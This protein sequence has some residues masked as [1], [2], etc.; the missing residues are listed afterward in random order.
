MKT[1]SFRAIFSGRAPLRADRPVFS[2]TPENETKFGS[3]AITELAALACESDARLYAQGVFNLAQR[4]A[5]QDRFEAAADLY[6][7]LIGLDMVSF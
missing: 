4:L 7:T 3:P 5:S 2:L 6:A 1:G